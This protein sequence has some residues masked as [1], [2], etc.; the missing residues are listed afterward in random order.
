MG[1]NKAVVKESKKKEINYSRCWRG[2][3]KSLLG[4]APPN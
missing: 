4:E 1:K 3:E 2:P